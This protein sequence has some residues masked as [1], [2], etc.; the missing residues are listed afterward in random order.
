MP[1]EDMARMRAE[2][3]RSLQRQQQA[4]QATPS[5]AKS[6]LDE[7]HKQSLPAGVN[8]DGAEEEMP[9]LFNIEEGEEEEDFE[10]DPE[11]I[12]ADDDE[13]TK[14][15]AQARKHKEM[16][17][18]STRLTKWQDKSVQEDDIRFQ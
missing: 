1:N 12:P 18:Y 8:I 14:A 2:M 10:D 3:E 5:T 11:L 17:D 9:P 7:A 16:I 4:Q 13:T 15:P 6:D